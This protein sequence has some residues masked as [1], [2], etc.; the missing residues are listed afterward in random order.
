L[1]GATGCGWDNLA[2]ADIHFF[3]LAAFAFGALDFFFKTSPPSNQIPL[4]HF[5]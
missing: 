3:F 4:M 1:Y 5:T 2:A